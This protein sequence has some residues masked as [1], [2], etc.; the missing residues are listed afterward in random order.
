MI[1]GYL[2]GRGKEI[3]FLYIEINKLLVYQ[4]IFTVDVPFKKATV[5][6]ILDVILFVGISM[7]ASV[8][9]ILIVCNGNSRQEII[10][11]VFILP[12]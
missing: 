3:L 2:R 4:Q 10:F 12:F 8:C 1:G 7:D 6:A 9:K 11:S 5:N